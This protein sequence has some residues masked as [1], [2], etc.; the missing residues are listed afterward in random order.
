LLPIDETFASTL[1][2]AFLGVAAPLGISIYL[3]RR[4]YQRALD[5]AF[6]QCEGYA[7]GVLARA[8][9]VMQ[10]LPPNAH[11][12]KTEAPALVAK[13]FESPETIAPLLTGAYT[14]FLRSQD[15]FL[16]WQSEQ[17][18]RILFANLPTAAQADP[19]ML[20]AALSHLHEHATRRAWIVF[21]M[22]RKVQP[23]F[24]IKSYN[25]LITAMSAST[26]RKLSSVKYEPPIP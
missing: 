6:V 24:S 11:R 13:N 1:L 9:Y 12:F 23:E 22:T 25:G 18:L 4:N 26:D 3:D 10:N 8:R 21:G 5:V 17:N 15:L 20:D 16:L 7:Q 14:R 19:K 2:G